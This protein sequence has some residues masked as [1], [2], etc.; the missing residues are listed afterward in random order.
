MRSCC[1]KWYGR[2]CRYADGIRKSRVLGLWK[3]RHA[4]IDRWAGSLGTGKIP[5]GSVFRAVRVLQSQTRQTQNLALGSQWLLVVL[6]PFG[7]RDICMAGERDNAKREYAKAPLVTGR[8]DAGT[9]KGTSS[10]LGT[11]G[12]I[13]SPFFLVFRDQTGQFPPMMEV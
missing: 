1:R 2:W 13:M 11:N 3:H 10:G 8:T 5:A 9:T 12:G 4:K 7:T 6:P